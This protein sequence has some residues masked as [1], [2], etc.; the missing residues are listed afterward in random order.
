M[1]GQQTSEATRSRKTSP[2]TTSP[3]RFLHQRATASSNGGESS[4]L[5]RPPQAPCPTSARVRVAPAA[6]RHHLR[7][8]HAQWHRRRGACNP[9]GPAAS[10]PAL[11]RSMA[12]EARS[13]RSARHARCRWT[14]PGSS[15]PTA[16]SDWQPET[17][18]TRRRSRSWSLRSA[19]AAVVALYL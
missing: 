8:R 14:L 12:P 5:R 17:R 10:A 7:L 3:P 4:L 6:L 11:A 9:Y 13:S 16:G 1:S 19:W 2:S 15:L 18:T